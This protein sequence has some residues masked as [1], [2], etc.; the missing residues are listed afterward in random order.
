MP[1]QRKSRWLGI[2]FRLLAILVALALAATLAF[3]LLLWFGIFLI[4]EGQKET[5]GSSREREKSRA[6]RA[7]KHLQKYSSDGTLT[8]RELSLALPNWHIKHETSHSVITSLFLA[9]AREHDY[10]ARFTLSLPLRPDSEVTRQDL[11]PKS[12]PCRRA[13]RTPVPE[14]DADTPVIPVGTTD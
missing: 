13:D 9:D 10:C 1:G 4:A 8:R 3:M 12:E 6:E 14:N 5:I 7:R 11:P 2:A